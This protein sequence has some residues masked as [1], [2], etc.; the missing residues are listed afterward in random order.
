MNN[1][2]GQYNMNKRTKPTEEYDFYTFEVQP[3]MGLKFSITERYASNLCKE[4]L[5]INSLNI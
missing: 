5:K 2:Q 3:K 1:K 4:L